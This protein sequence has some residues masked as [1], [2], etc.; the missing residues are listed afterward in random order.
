[1]V[2][3][4]PSALTLIKHLWFI[5]QQH[6]I[7]LEIQHVPGELNTLADACS[8]QQW[9][10]FNAALQQWHL[11]YFVLEGYDHVRSST[12]GPSFELHTSLQN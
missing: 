6:D 4:P 5:C 8:R 2:A 3:K 12:F 9:S 7:I 1:M 10:V 11:D